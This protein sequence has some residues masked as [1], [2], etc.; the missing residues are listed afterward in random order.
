MPGDEPKYDEPKSN[1]HVKL[2]GAILIIGLIATLLLILITHPS[3]MT[4]VTVPTKYIPAY[5][6]IEDSDLTNR[7]I[8]TIL[9]PDNTIQ[10]AST[11]I[12]RYTL[13]SR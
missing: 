7:S 3:V 12:G 9:I 6:L 1:F 5:H 10:D 2:F 13:V 11:A 8:L 4:T